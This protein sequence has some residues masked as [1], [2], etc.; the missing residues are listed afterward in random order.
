L[1]TFKS[2]SASEG[3]GSEGLGSEGGVLVSKACVV[4]S[5]LWF[6]AWVLWYI[7]KSYINVN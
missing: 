6:I 4:S 5:V 7:V 1:N 2:G 3:L